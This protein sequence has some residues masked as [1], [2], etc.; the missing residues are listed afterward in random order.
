MVITGSIE[1]KSPKF[2]DAVKDE[3]KAVI[4]P[5]EAKP[6]QTVTIKIRV[7]LNPGWYTYPTVQE[8]KG[9]YGQV[10]TFKYQ[11]SES[12]IPVG[13]AIEPPNPKAKPEPDLKIEKLSYY[14]GN[15]IF[16]RKAVISP[17]A[18]SGDASVAMRMKILV[19]ND[20]NC[21]PKEFDLK[22]TVRIAGSAV[23]VDAKYKEEVE[24]VLKK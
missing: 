21:I 18:K 14:P 5:A 12:V 23:A 9:A 10:T 6:G 11:K 1:A 16:E 13:T 15:V 7:E 24:K 2:E 22:P 3:I 19:C 20:K 8:D 17:L 4:E